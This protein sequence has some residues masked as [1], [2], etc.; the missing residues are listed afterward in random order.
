MF[1]VIFMKKIYL[2]LI[3][4]LILAIGAYIYSSKNTPSTTVSENSISTTNDSVVETIDE[5]K[6]YTDV[7]PIKLGI[8]DKNSSNTK[9]IL[10]SDVVKPW[11]YHKD[12]IEYNVFYTQDEEI[13][14][15]RLPIC[16]D[17]YASTY[18]DDISNYR[19]GY[20]VQFEIG[21]KIINKTILSPKDTEEFYDYLEVYLYDGYHRKPG[22]WYSH[23]TEEEFN[24]DTLLL[25][26]KLTSGKEVSKISS[27]IV[28]TA[29]SYDNTNSNDF[30]SNGNYRGNS[31]YSITIEKSNSN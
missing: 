16:F 30:D 14:A 6:T 2:V 8:Y 21:D 23:T 7:N 24:K 22:E 26:I 12:I 17:K 11:T 19:I 13:D 27:D 15:T 3:F 31:K 20:N 1:L 18:T 10:I 4:I 5:V 9:R 29:F 28:L 25:G